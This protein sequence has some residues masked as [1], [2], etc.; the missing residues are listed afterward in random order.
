MFLQLPPQPWLSRTDVTI[1]DDWVDQSA[2]GS[3]DI[4]PADQVKGVSSPCALIAPQG[5]TFP[6]AVSRR[7][8][9][10]LL[11]SPERK[12]GRLFIPPPSYLKKAFSSFTIVAGI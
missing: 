1:G 7:P 8:E 5:T 12:R 3:Q 11:Y 10:V 2:D 4:L 6:T 9:D